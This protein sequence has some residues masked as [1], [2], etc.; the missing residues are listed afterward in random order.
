MVVVAYLLA[1]AS[2]LSKEIGLTVMALFVVH[3][4]MPALYGNNNNNPS[5]K[6]IMIAIWDRVCQP[7]VAIRVSAHILVVAGKYSSSYS[8]SSS[9]GIIP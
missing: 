6:S 9:Y 4:M 8:S 7:S 5:K 3:D 2:F 1:V